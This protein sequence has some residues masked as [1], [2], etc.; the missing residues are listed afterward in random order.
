MKESIEQAIIETVTKIKQGT[1]HDEDMKHSQ[2]VLNL[3]NSLAT[4]N[5][6]S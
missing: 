2:A 5:N 6:L 1:S 3:M 4:L